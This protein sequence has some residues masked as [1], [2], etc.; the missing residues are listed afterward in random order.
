MEGSLK[1]LRE[2]TRSVNH[3]LIFE[4]AA[5][6]E[7]FTLAAEELNVTQP[8]VSRSIRELEA[9]LGV[10]LF[11][12]G[13][14]SVALTEEGKLL[15][16]TAS[17]AFGRMLETAKQLHRRTRQSHVTVVTTSSF[18]NYWL[19]PRLS[20]FNRRHRDI[21]LRIQISDRYPD[22]S[23]DPA[24]LA[25]W[26]G[27]GSWPGCEGALLASEEVFPVASPSFVKAGG[28]GSDPGSLARE[29]LIHL[30]EPFIPVLTWSDWFREMNVDY[31]DGGK[32]LWFNDYTPAL[33][34]AMAGEGIALGWRH[35]VRGLMEMGLLV[36]IGERSLRRGGQGCYLVWSSSVSL[37]PQT[38]AV[39]AW[40]REAAR[41]K[42]GARRALP[43]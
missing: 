39:R 30:E 19:L 40:F 42:A 25:A 33:H 16:D 7:S 13:H 41:S 26:W 20:D 1:A 34:A 21:D 3:L 10:T 22:L 35:V 36:R 2:L 15:Y 5:R 18:A 37:A 28:G 27:D 32:G 12:R 14:R 8:A 31:H 43:C 17:A 4:T 11:R 23:E 24:S 38:L 9:A 29:S 6:F